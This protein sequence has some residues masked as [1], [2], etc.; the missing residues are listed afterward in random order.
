[1][2]KRA[3]PKGSGVVLRAMKLSATILGFDEVKM[4]IC[5]AFKACTTLLDS[6]INVAFQIPCEASVD[7]QDMICGSSGVSGINASQMGRKH[8]ILSSG[9]S[10]QL[11]WLKFKLSPVSIG[12][13]GANQWSI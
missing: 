7:V 9:C 11:R 13:Q 5:A 12:Y 4:K 10:L 6:D 8:T 2:A 1:V 3:Q